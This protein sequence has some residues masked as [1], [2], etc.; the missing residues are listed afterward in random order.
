MGSIIVNDNRLEIKEFEGFTWIKKSGPDNLPVWLQN[1][2]ILSN[3]EKKQDWYISDCVEFT[4]YAFLSLHKAISQ[5]PIHLLR[6]ICNTYRA[7]S[8]TKS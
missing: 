6:K 4:L 5:K 3:I 7:A 8:G 1:S 2:D